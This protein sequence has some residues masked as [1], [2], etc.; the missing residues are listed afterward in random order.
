[1]VIP[2]DLP[3]RRQQ[4]YRTARI[5]LSCP[6]TRPEGVPQNGLYHPLPPYEVREKRRDGND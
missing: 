4:E 6:I 3:A 5:A 2:A 1:V